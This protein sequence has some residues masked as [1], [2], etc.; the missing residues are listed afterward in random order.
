MIMLK[1]NLVI[2]KNKPSFFLNLSSQTRQQ[3]K[4]Q[5]LTFINQIDNEPLI[6]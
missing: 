4:I 2:G 6:A 5:L 1:K 3:L